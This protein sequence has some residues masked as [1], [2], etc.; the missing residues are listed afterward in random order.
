LDSDT[1][2][3]E[4]CGA[5]LGCMALSPQCLIAFYVYL[6]VRTSP[7]LVVAALGAAVLHVG[8]TRAIKGPIRRLA[9]DQFSVVADVVTR[10]QESIQGIRVVKSFG[11]EAFEI[12]LLHR[13]LR[14]AV[15]VSVRFGVYKHMEKPTRAVV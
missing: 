6:L 10:L 11:A 5:T 15:R 4:A 8:V 13:I 12:S 14:E 9:T 1:A 2:A 3:R 7:K